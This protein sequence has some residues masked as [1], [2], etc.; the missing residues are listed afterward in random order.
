MD[1]RQLEDCKAKMPTSFLEEMYQS[2]VIS[3]AIVAPEEEPVC[4]K[5]LSLLSQLFLRKAPI[6]DFSL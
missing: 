6:I 1:I 5:I 4:K 3:L 2:Y